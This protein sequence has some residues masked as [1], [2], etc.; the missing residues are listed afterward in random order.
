MFVANVI[1]SI[2]PHP[3]LVARIGLESERN[4]PSVRYRQA[5]CWPPSPL[6]EDVLFYR[7]CRPEMY[8]RF[9]EFVFVS[10]SRGGQQ[11]GA[12][13]R[14]A[15]LLVCGDLGLNQDTCEVRTDASYSVVSD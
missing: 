1:S 3:L 6:G 4:A 10:S 7:A 9:V 13:R 5:L 8:A 11:R 2:A 14:Q 12:R 15:V